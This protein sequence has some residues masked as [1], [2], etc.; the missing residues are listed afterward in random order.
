MKCQATENTYSKNSS[1]TPQKF[2]IYRS[3][4]LIYLTSII[5]LNHSIPFSSFHNT[6][7]WKELF[8]WKGTTFVYVL[9]S[10]WWISGFTPKGV[11]IRTGHQL[12]KQVFKA[13]L[14][15]CT[16]YSVDINQAIYIWWQTVNIRL[17]NIHNKEEINPIL[18]P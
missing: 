13:F 16:V 17:H 11:A 4:N 7:K 14:P 1:V 5:S 2:S 3:C 10:D 15:T 18:A 12:W 8:P 9:S 6:T